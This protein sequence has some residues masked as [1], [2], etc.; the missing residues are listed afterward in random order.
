MFSEFIS[1][2]EKSRCVMHIIKQWSLC[3]F[4][5]PYT[6]TDLGLPHD[7]GNWTIAIYVHELTSKGLFISAM[8][9][10]GVHPRIWWHNTVYGM[11]KMTLSL[12][13]RHN[14]HDGVKNHQPHGCLL[15]SLIH[16]QI[17]GK[18]QSSASLAFV[19]GIPRDRWIP[20][21]KGQ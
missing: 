4:L 19:R 18:H 16:A 1:H 8:W 6:K 13:W 20:R 2:R 17:K 12:Q 7:D 3:Q 9:F 14:D 10:S 21:T 11:R 15:Q 5:W